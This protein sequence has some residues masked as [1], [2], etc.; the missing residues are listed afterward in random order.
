MCRSHDCQTSPASKWALAPRGESATLNIHSAAY[1]FKTAPH[2][3]MLKEI[4]KR[5][6]EVNR[7]GLLGECWERIMFTEQCRLTDG[8]IKWRKRNINAAAARFSP[9]TTAE[10]SRVRM[11]TASR[12]AG[13]SSASSSPIKTFKDVHLF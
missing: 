13:S 12:S 10:G 11:L 6:G 4:G 9:I 3:C 1:E 7:N 2:C 5:L 8:D